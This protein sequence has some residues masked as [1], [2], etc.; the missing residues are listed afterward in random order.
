MGLQIVENENTENNLRCLAAQRQLYSEAKRVFFLQI[1]LTT[2]SIVFLSLLD[3]FYNIE[4]V[5]ATY[6]FVV[7]I[8][9]LTII[10]PLIKS[11]KEKAAIVQEYFDSTVLEIP[12][13]H[14][15]VGNRPDYEEIFRYSEK[16]KKK[17]DFTTLENWY[18]EKVREIDTDAAKIIC[19]RS[20]CVYD[21]TIRDSFSK[22]IN[23]IL[24]IAAFL[25][26]II[27]LIKGVTLQNFFLLVGLPVL[28]IIILLGQ[29]AENNKVSKDSLNNLKETA[30]ATWGRVLKKELINVNE[31][32]RLLQDKIF[33]NRRN[34][35]LIFD[36]YYKRHRSQFESE[37]EFSVE[38]IVK[39]YKEHTS[40]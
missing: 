27:G 6:S 39:Q 2:I 3:I 13:N 11:R 37:M 1:T 33:L 25:I 21:Y 16:Y 20:S 22:L 32:A 23:A 7:T 5:V 14:V 28:P 19:Q 10:T 15:L 17:A 9:D 26:L 36:W 18:S 4:W 35:P 38:Q 8:S 30:D 12:W 29:L 24:I 40:I 31:V 34:S